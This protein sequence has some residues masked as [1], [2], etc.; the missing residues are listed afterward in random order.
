[1]VEFNKNEKKNNNEIWIWITRTHVGT[2]I[3]SVEM[4][5]NIENVVGWCL[6]LSAE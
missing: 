4:K 6:T 5:K 2:K 3:D 1:M